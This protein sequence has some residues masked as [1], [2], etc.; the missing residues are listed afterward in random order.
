LW[1][2]IE[3]GLLL[4]PIEVVFPILRQSLDIRTVENQ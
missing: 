3:R 4:L 2:L 1:M